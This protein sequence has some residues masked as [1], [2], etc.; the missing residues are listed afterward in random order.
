MIRIPGS[1]PQKRAIRSH[2]RPPQFTLAPNFTDVSLENELAVRSTTAYDSGSCLYV[3]SAIQDHAPKCTRNGFV[4]H[5]AG[6]TDQQASNSGGVR[7]VLSYFFRTQP[8]HPDQPIGL[9]SSMQ[10]FQP[11]DFFFSGGNDDFPATLV[12]D[13]FLF[14]KTV[15]CFP[16]FGA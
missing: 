1:T 8:S 3:A 6:F 15:H 14:A 2:W 16:S 9:P 10:F 5:D 12:G 4:I 13:A 11:W 7:F